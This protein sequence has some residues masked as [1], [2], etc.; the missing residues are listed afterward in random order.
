MTYNYLIL[1]IEDK[2]AMVTINRPKALNAI[3]R[4]LMLELGRLFSEDLKEQ[5]VQGVI[6]TGS[7]EKAFVAGADIKGFSG[8]S[9]E[10]GAQL[11]REGHD[12]YQAI[13][14]FKAPVIAV[15]NGYALGGGCELA[16]ACHMRI[17]EE[18]ARF[19]QPEVNLGLI[20]GYGGTQRLP[21]LVGRA[22]AIELLVT[23][24]MVKAE[25]AVRI[26]LANHVVPKGEGMSK[27]LKILGKVKSKAPLAVQEIIRCVNAFDRDGEDGFDLEVKRF[28]WCFGTEDFKE[29]TSAFMEKREA[30]FTGQ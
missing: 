26:G 21:R 5:D 22:K 10:E 2:I 19:G 1:E 20:P 13:E 30:H 27:A 24:D 25:E 9:V 11:A 8:Y 17:A 12:A 7:G 6:V 16:M 23:G 28:G 3:N 14:E 29:G 15:V 4:D 18:N